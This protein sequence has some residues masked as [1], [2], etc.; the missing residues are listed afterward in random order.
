M[1]TNS[2]EKKLFLID[3]FAIIFRSYFAFGSNQRYNSQGLNTS[4]TLGFANTLLEILKKQKPSHIAVVFDM[5]GKTFRNELFP[6]YKAHR[7]E[8]PE[9]II[10]SI[11]YVRQLIDGFNIPMLGEVGFEADDVIG[12]ISKMAEKE[13]FQTF[14]MTP[15]KDFAQLVSDNI[16]MYKPARSGKPAEVWG[17]P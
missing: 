5:P 10:A 16:F 7:N 17:V 2:P 1:S 9:D 14:M 6:E 13:G 11:P 15:D 12:T 4:V 3:A 8:T